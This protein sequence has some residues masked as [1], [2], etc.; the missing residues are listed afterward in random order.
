M[1]KAA[2]KSRR[3]TNSSQEKSEFGGYKTVF[4]HV[5]RRIGLPRAGCCQQQRRSSSTQLNTILNLFQRNYHSKGVP[6]DRESKSPALIVKT[7]SDSIVRIVP[8]DEGA[9]SRGGKMDLKS[10]AIH[11]II[12][13]CGSQFD[14]LTMGIV[15]RGGI[16]IGDL[17]WDTDHIFGPALV[18]AYDLESNF[19]VY[20]RIVLDAEIA[21]QIKGETCGWR[22]AD[23]AREDFDG[24]W[25]VDYLGF[26]TAMLA[27]NVVFNKEQHHAPFEVFRSHIVQQLSNFEGLN[28]ARL[29]Y[30]W[31]ASY[32]NRVVA[33]VPVEFREKWAYL[34]IP[35]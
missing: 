25:F 32:F 28:R 24:V 1:P 18:R 7:F 21:D 2:A 11:E 6:G 12:D 20:P 26:Y 5:R 33:A 8:L 23:Y 16:T 10:E 4:M 22:G 34:S 35:I 29:K 15:V 17:Y 3:R 13:L 30:M 27:P 19:A 31:L 14:L 9:F